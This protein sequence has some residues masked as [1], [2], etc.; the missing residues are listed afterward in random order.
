MR[1]LTAPTRSPGPSGL[2]THPAASVHPPGRSSPLGFLRAVAPARSAYLGVRSPLQPVP[3]HP[4]PSGTVRPGA[5]S[6]PPGPVREGKGAGSAGGVT[7]PARTSAS[8]SL[9]SVPC[10]SW[11]FRL[12]QRR[13]FGA[14]VAEGGIPPQPLSPLPTQEEP[15]LPAL[16]LAALAGG[17]ARNWPW[18]LR[19]GLRARSPPGSSS[20]SWPGLAGGP[21]NLLLEPA[22]LGKLE[23]EH[24]GG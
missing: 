3:P 9:A 16:P 10:A 19:L 18:S 20:P 2:G 17:R 7:A 6:P 14:P 23:K 5:S 1:P 21:P 13:R 22:R 12:G 4:A 8:C 15:F 24:E 11:L